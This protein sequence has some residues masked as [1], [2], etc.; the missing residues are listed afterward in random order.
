MRIDPLDISQARTA[1]DGVVRGLKEIDPTLDLLHS[2]DQRWI[3]CRYAP[4]RIDREVAWDGLKNWTASVRRSGRYDRTAHARIRQCRLALVGWRQIGVYVVRNDDFGF[5]V[6]DARASQWLR[7]HTSDN[8]LFQEIDAQAYEKRQAARAE[9]ADRERGR[10]VYQY[11]K[12]LNVMPS[13]S[14]TPKQ[15]V[16]S[17][18]QRI[19]SV[20]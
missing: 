7:D 2:R 14:L 15:P 10:A 19:M 13:A 3:L 11:V 4:D 6:S 20:A 9:I 16:R 1:P 17:G 5:I 8:Q 12:Q 18:F